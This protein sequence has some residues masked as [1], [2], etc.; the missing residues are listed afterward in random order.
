MSG[1][2]D[3]KL[4][5]N[6][7]SLCRETL[8]REMNTLREEGA[9]INLSPQAICVA[10]IVAAIH[11]QALAI[12]G[13]DLDLKDFDDLLESDIQNIRGRLAEKKVARR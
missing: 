7:S 3:E 9:R 11:V 8:G 4:L 5:P 12:V 1:M 6:F 13:G 2:R 10:I